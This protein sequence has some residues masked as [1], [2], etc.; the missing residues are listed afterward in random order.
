[1]L[2][3]PL[4]FPDNKGVEEFV[5]TLTNIPTLLASFVLITI[6]TELSAL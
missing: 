3:N 2:A 4:K 6:S 1:V 5:L